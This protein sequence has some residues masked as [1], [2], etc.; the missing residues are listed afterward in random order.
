MQTMTTLLTL[1]HAC[2]AVQSAH[3]HYLMA[4]DLLDSLCDPRKN[5]LEA[6]FRDEQSRQESY[7]G[8][9]SYFDAL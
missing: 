9:F 1:Q 8:K 5:R 7:R 4:M 3:H 6:I 2:N